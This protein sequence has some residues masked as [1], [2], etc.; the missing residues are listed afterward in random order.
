MG[1]KVDDLTLG[2]LGPTEFFGELSLLPIEGGCT[3]FPLPSQ[4]LIHI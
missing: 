4:F 1:P 2:T 3:H